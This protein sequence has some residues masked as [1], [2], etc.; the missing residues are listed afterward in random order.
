MPR[1]PDRIQLRLEPFL[2]KHGY[3]LISRIIVKTAPCPVAQYKCGKYTDRDQKPDF[4]KGC[5]PGCWF[6][7][8]FVRLR[9]VKGTPD[10]LYVLLPCLCIFISKHISVSKIL[11]LSDFDIFYAGRLGLFHFLQQKNCQQNI[12]W[13]DLCA[14][15]SSALGQFTCNVF[16]CEP[17]F[18]HQHHQM[19]QKIRRFIFDL[20][21]IRVFCRDYDLGR[22]FPDLF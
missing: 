10:L 19:I 12:Y 16:P 13:Q 14:D 4:K 7:L 8:I 6:F 20:F 21:R 2:L 3:N 5:R 15:H 11:S 17:F 1:L 18:H 22:F 9:M